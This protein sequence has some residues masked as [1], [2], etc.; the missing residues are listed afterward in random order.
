MKALYVA[1][2]GPRSLLEPDSRLWQGAGTERVPLTGTPLAL[3]PTAAIQVSW[4]DKPI[5]AVHRVS[6]S[7]LHDGTTI[8]FRLEWPDASENRTTENTTSFPD[9]AAIA[10]PVRAG[11]PLQTMGAPGLAV[12]AWYWRADEEGG[13][14]I[15]VAEGIGSSRTVGQLAS[16]SRSAWKGGRWTVV[17]TRPLAPRGSEPLA[18]LEPG[19][20]TQY[21]IAVWEGSHRERA[22][23]KA[24]S[25]TWREIQIEAV[26]GSGR[27]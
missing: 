9:A 5:G 4:R 1:S 7:A 20:R 13:V 19:S 14:R 10:F 11:A 23:I 8:A 18:L 16:A 24:F 21:G 2:L 6:V 3:Q 26:P 17:I 25:G 12:N 22:G 15:V 27:S